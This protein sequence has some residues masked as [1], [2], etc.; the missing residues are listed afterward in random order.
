LSFSVANSDAEADIAN[1]RKTNDYGKP[2]YWG[3]QLFFENWD[4]SP[5]HVVDAPEE[6]SVKAEV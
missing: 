6:V 2:M 1:L 3:G 4:A 5:A